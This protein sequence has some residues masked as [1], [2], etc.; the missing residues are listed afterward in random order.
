MIILLASGPPSSSYRYTASRPPYYWTVP[1]RLV[2]E[3]APNSVHSPIRMNPAPAAILNMEMG[4]TRV[5]AEPA[6]TAMALDTTSAIADAKKTPQA[7]NCCS[8]VKTIVASWVLSP[9]SATRTLRKTTQN[10]LFMS[11]D[12]VFARLDLNRCDYT[13]YALYS[14]HVS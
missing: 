12:C 5:K 1:P 13:L 6:R 4:A 10:C 9:I 14:C 3:R 7:L 8:V 11:R 2:H